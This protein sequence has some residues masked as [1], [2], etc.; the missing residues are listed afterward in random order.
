MR[1]VLKRIIEYTSETRMFESNRENLHTNKTEAGVKSETANEKIN[2][3][4][5]CVNIAPT[6][7]TTV[8]LNYK[9]SIHE[10]TH[11]YTFYMN[12]NSNGKLF[13]CKIISKFLFFFWKW[14]KIRR[15]FN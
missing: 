9:N 15:K 8:T 11:R 6:T 7:T 12:T 1:W 4:L 10:F 3:R 5:N 13:N 2:W 14:M